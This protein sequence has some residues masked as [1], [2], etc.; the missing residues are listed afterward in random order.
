M[1]KKISKHKKMWTCEHHI[2]VDDFLD[3][4]DIK[5]EYP[6]DAPDDYPLWEECEGCHDYKPGENKCNLKI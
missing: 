3:V 2:F 6:C 5:G 1:P 4:C